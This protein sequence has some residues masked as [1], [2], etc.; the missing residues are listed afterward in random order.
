MKSIVFLLQAGCNERCLFCFNH[1][2]EHGQM[3]T[4]SPAEKRRAIDSVI[5]L[6]PSMI[7]LSGGEPLL[8]KGLPSLVDYIRQKA[9]QLPLSI[10][11]NGTLLTPELAARF[12]T[13][14]YFFISLHGPEKIHNELTR[15]PF[16]HK[17][18]Q[19]IRIA[20]AAG[21]PVVLNTV[22][23][24]ANIVSLPMFLKEC[25][26]L[27]IA[28]LQLS[29]LYAAGVARSRHYL[30]PSMAQQRELVQAVSF[31]SLPYHVTF[32]AFE[33][34]LLQGTPF[35]A[36]HCGAG[37]EEIAIQPNGDVTLCPAWEQTYGNIML[38]DWSVI[39][40]QMKWGLA[41]EKPII[42]AC[43]DCGGCALSRKAAIMEQSG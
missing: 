18:M 20:A 31:L 12:R 8:D 35:H 14:N 41:Q 16:F 32:H 27:G 17:T 37:D 13:V 36:D 2:R 33:K 1:W 25:A 19:G 29:A 42:S 30:F 4:L 3:A 24:R 6:A 7:T 22:V 23:T 15:G 5:A 39:E 11:T 26:Q 38:D 10:Q 9:P 34:H 43:Q 28:A 21:I 40:Q